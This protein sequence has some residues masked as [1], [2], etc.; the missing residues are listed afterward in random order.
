VNDFEDLTEAH[1]DRTI[2]SNLHGYFQMAKAAVPRTKPGSAADALIAVTDLASTNTR[3]MRRAR[4]ALFDGTVGKDTVAVDKERPGRRRSA[5][6]PDRCRLRH[7]KLIG[8]AG[9]SA[10]LM[11]G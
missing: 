3:R 4:V 7:R 5:R 6:A 11:L 10:E 9:E 2:K 8:I 1:F